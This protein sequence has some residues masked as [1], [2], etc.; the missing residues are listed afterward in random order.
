[1]RFVM[2]ELTSNSGYYAMSVVSGLDCTG[3]RAVAVDKILVLIG[4][5]SAVVFIQ[6]ETV[7]GVSENIGHIEED[8]LGAD[9]ETNGSRM[10]RSVIVGVE[11]LIGRSLVVVTSAEYE[12][13]GNINFATYFE[14]MTHAVLVNNI[15]ILDIEVVVVSVELGHG[16]VYKIVFSGDKG[17]FVDEE[18][19]AQVELQGCGERETIAVVVT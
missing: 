3:R 10:C 12:L 15:L 19:S 9:A 16:V 8:I 17:A 18:R 4:R 11:I 7:V 5:E 14:C 13:G 6:P 2:L 1:M